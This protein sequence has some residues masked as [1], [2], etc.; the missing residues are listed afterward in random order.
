MKNKKQLIFIG[1]LP[2]PIHGFSSI[3]L[4]MLN[5]LKLKYKNI[6]IIDPT[7]KTFSK[8]KIIKK[9]VK[10]IKFI[11]FMPKLLKFLKKNKK[12]VTYVSLSGSYGLVFDIIY[13][14]VCSFF[15]NTFFIH[16]HSYNY[17]NKKNFLI[18]LLLKIISD[19]QVKHFVLCLDM[20]KSLSEIYDISPNDIIIQSNALFI[21]DNDFKSSLKKTITNIGFFGSIEKSKGIFEFLE[22]ASLA[23]QLYK[24]IKFHVAGQIT[25]TKLKQYILN[26]KNINYLGPLYGV[27]KKNYFR[28]IDILLYPSFNDAEPLVVLEAL[29]YGVVVISSDVGCIKN[30][31][32]SKCGFL[33]DK[34]KNFPT[35]F[36]NILS[37]LLSN[38]KLLQ[39]FSV[40]SKL[41]FD[42]LASKNTIFKYL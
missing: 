6:F 10:L 21:S 37:N 12:F 31:L 4:F 18:Q 34:N 30:I 9:L 24:N 14:Y 25:D 3:N 39:N 16:H 36:F 19:F 29:S 23:S 28:K 27:Q 38:N 22:S 40:N 11:F 13:V 32:N 17:I 8:Y 41:R 1:P 33:I 26:Y 15:E 42:E 20:K 35:I 7:M 5:E 2:P